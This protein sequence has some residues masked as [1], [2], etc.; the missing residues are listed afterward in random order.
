MNFPNSR[1]DVEASLEIKDQ[2]KEIFIVVI[3]LHLK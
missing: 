1:L 2:V 3:D